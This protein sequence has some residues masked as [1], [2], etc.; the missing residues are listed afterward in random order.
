MCGGESRIHVDEEPPEPELVCQHRET[1][2]GQLPSLGL[3]LPSP[4]CADVDEVEGTVVTTTACPVTD[5]P[6]VGEVGVAQEVARGVRQPS[7][8]LPEA[9]GPG[10]ADRAVVQ[11]LPHPWL[12]RRG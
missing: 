7:T 4:R 5:E 3:G 1:A 12:V 11:R 6:G 9:M 2:L 8:R 10:F